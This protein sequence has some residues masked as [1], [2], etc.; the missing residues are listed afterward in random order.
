MSMQMVMV[1]IPV[2]A[3]VAFWAANMV[4]AAEQEKCQAYN[5]SCRWSHQRVSTNG[6]LEFSAIV[7]QILAAAVLVGYVV[8]AVAV[9]TSPELAL[10]MCFMIG[11][12]YIAW[13]L[14]H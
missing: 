13:D 10:A 14:T 12:A 7:V 11:G 5:A 1:L 4:R 2:V 3:V 8:I 9:L 6:V